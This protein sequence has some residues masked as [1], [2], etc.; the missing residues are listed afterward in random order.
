MNIYVG[1]IAH[2]STEEGL[3]QLFEQFG[4]VASARIILDRMTGKSR[5]FAFIEMPND[6]EGTN[7]I[8]SLNETEF[9]GRTIRVTAA[10]PKPERS[11]RPFAPRG[12]GRNEGGYNGGGRGRF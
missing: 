1:N 6:S 12:G 3:K 5:G 4:S 9:D 2:A 10:Q 8:E 11:S 7:A